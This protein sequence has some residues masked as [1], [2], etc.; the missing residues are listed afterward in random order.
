VRF[1]NHLLSLVA[2][3]LW[4]AGVEFDGEPVPTRTVGA[5]TDPGGDGGAVGRKLHPA[6]SETH[7]VLEAGGVAG[8]EQLF[9]VGGWATW[10]A[11][12][13][14]V[15]SREESQRINL[16]GTRNVFEATV[17]ADRPRRL[18][19]SSS[20]AAY[21]YHADNPV[22]LT[23]D[24]PARGSPEHYYSAQKAACEALLRQ[25]TAGADLEVYVLR[26]CIVA[27]P[28]ATL[29][30]RSLPWRRAAEHLPDT[31]RR[32]LGR[33]PGLPVLPDPGVRF[34]LVHHDDVATAV[35]LAVVG[36]GPPGTYNLAGDGEVTLSEFARALGGSAVPVP[37]ALVGLAS[38]L[39][40]RLPFLPAEMEWVHAARHPM[41]MDTTRARR[42]LGWVP[43]HT[44]QE[45]LTAMVDAERDRAAR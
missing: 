16:A 14:I 17:S 38:T 42:Q 36:A 45:T 41:L 26:P 33:V 5:D 12:L 9:R 30:V 44:A 18:V 34:Q 1:G 19:Y 24:V 39:V 40:E 8:G 31:A 10:A 3:E 22:P 29:L 43:A 7:R 20:L 6:G 13:F 4:Q 11:Q 27:G 21:G 37:C 23:E 2:I 28:E 35:C 15:G 32:M 25:T